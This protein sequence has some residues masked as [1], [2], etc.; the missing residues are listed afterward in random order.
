[1]FNHKRL[2]T[3][4][5][6]FIMTASIILLISG[7]GGSNHDLSGTLPEFEKYPQSF[8][9]FAA[10]ANHEMSLEWK[11]VKTLLSDAGYDLWHPIDNDESS[12]FMLMPNSEDE[13]EFYFELTT[14]F[15]GVS[16]DL[17]DVTVLMYQLNTDTDYVKVDFKDGND[18]YT[19]CDYTYT[20]N[21]LETEEWEVSTL[22]ELMEYAINALDDVYKQSF[23]Y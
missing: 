5:T 2:Y 20:D 17:K 4:V 19:I 22:D 18:K 23:G 21:G 16:E 3:I 1:M 9:I 11:D 12:G 14:L 13:Q 6:V 15:G 7:C 10:Y 8:S